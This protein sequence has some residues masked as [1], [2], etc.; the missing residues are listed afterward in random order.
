M[1]SV[2]ILIK[3]SLTPSAFRT[4]PTK[5]GLSRDQAVFFHAG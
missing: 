5:Q 2:K 1:S 3:H 4:A